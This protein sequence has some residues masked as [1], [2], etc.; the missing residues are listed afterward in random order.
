MP[1]DNEN[2]CEVQND[3]KFELNRPLEVFFVHP[4]KR[5]GVRPRVHLP[6]NTFICEYAGVLMQDRE[7]EEELPSEDSYIYLL[8]F[9][10]VCVY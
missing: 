3:A 6:P 10:S 9:V 5:W 2:G 4:R 8:K 1:E 7:E